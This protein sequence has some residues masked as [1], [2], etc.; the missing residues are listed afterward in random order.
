MSLDELSKE[1]GGINPA[2]LSRLRAGSQSVGSVVAK[3]IA[4]NLAKSQSEI[5]RLVSELL[6]T[7]SPHNE[8]Q[9][10]HDVLVDESV[11]GL[12]Y[13]VEFRERPAMSDP[14]GGDEIRS[15][16]ARWL[17][18]GLTYAMMSPYAESDGQ[19]SPPPEGSVE[20]LDYLRQIHLEVVRSHLSLREEMI[21]Q[22]LAEHPAEL[23]NSAREEARS[24]DK[25]LKLYVFSSSF[26]GAFPAIGYK[27]YLA[28]RD[29]RYTRFEWDR[30]PVTLS[31]F[32]DQPADR[33]I[34]NSDSPEIELAAVR[35]RFFPILKWFDE[36]KTLPQN[37]GDLEDMVQLTPKGSPLLSRKSGSPHPWKVFVPNESL[38]ELVTR[39]V[40]EKA[41]RERIS[42]AQD[43][44]M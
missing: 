37:D 19:N 18:D 42:K 11:Q 17:R 2:M 44:G 1:L 32:A 16:V 38:D 8:A 34:S 40:I 25:R 28:A 43:R 5:D 35:S 22:W 33:L 20:V 30:R 21:R 10:A 7:S 36:Y 24:Y 9:R 15:L 39:L 23:T 12:C 14:D 4:T 3:R 31:S 27:L 41:H 26:M 6:A 29:R 13:L